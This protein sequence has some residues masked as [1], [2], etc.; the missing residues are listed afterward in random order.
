MEI[1]FSVIKKAC[2]TGRST[3]TLEQ[4]WSMCPVILSIGI[5][6]FVFTKHELALLE[7][8]GCK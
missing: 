5:N 6:R 7:L 2:L 3:T 1:M 4:S 8:Q